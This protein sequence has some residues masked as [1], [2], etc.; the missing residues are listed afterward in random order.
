[1][2]EPAAGSF[3]GVPRLGAMFGRFRI[4]SVVGRGGMGIAFRATDTDLD[5]VVA[6]KF[7]APQMP[8]DQVARD[9]FMR[10]SRLA[11]AIEHPHIVPVHEAGVVHGTMF[12]AMRYIPGQDPAQLLRLEAPLDLARTLDIC[13]Q[14]ADALDAARARGL[15]H[16]D[17][18]PANVLLEDRGEEWAW[19][20]DFGLTRRIDGSVPSIADGLAGSIDYLAPEAIENGTVDGR[21][22]QYSLACLAYHCLAGTPPF[23]GATEPSVLYSHVHDQAPQLPVRARDG[24]GVLDTALQ[25]ALAKRADD[26]FPD[27]GSFVAALR[28]YSQLAM[29]SV[30]SC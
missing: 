6:L 30:P 11:A 20:S 24:A 15:I 23:E 29:F 4:E 19:L 7:L 17:V 21:A 16:R 27:C 13:A 5:R 28:G 18:K 25:R 3:G 22:D 14:L 2:S 26:M 12:I 9:R 10:E 8:A 1:V